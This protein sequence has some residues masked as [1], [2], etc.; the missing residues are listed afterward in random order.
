MSLY[1]DNTIDPLAV[2]PEG[3]ELTT[4]PWHFA[5]I[6]ITIEKP[7]KQATVRSWVWKNLTGRFSI[8]A[9]FVAFEDHTE[10]SMFALIKDQFEHDENFN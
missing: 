9:Q 7:N 10:A 2:I 3:R 4:C 5:K 6:A 1:I 8:A